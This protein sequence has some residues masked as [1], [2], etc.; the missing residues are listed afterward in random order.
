MLFRRLDA[1]GEKQAN[2][3]ILDRLQKLKE[4]KTTSNPLSK[5]EEIKNR[6]QNIK[7]ETPTTSD[8]EIYA[9]LAKLRGV[10]VEVV[11]AKVS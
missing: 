1:M 11:N 7:G 4:N 9:R 2:Q 6:L 5:D 3:E 8:A 10:P